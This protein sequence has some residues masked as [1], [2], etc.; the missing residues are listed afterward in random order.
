MIDYKQDRS[1]EDWLLFSDQKRCRGSTPLLPPGGLVAWLTPDFAHSLSYSSVDQ[2]KIT[3]LL[4]WQGNPRMQVRVL[5]ELLCPHGA[6]G[7]RNRLLSGRL[8]VRISLGVLSN[9]TCGT[10][11]LWTQKHAKRVMNNLPKSVASRCIAP[12]DA[13]DQE[14]VQ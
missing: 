14:A 8:G 12:R 9:D 7:Q 1:D 10:L 6:T 13:S 5:S 3:N 2:W 11:D 4:S